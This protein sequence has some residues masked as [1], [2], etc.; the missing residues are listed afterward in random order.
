MGKLVIFTGPMK[1]GKTTRLINTYQDEVKLGR[2]CF[3][4]KPELDN[5]FS[6]EEV[7]SRDGLSIPAISISRIDDIERY[8]FIGNSFFID[9]FQFLGGDINVILNLLD[10]NKSVYISGLNLTSDRTIFGLMGH[11]MP[12][13]NEIN[14]L[15]GN[16]DN[17]NKF[18][19]GVYTYCKTSK[20]SDILVGDTEYMCVCPS[21][22]KEL[23]NQ[24]CI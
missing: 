24:R 9:E 6:A 21:C 23:T 5:R 12:Y 1:S 19:S 4:F 8:G 20:S 14:I 18:N 10:K 11:I 7:V 15:T 3:L 17:C 2:R 22:Y 16:C 13:A